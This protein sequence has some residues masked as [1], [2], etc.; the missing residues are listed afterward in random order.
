MRKSCGE[1]IRQRIAMDRAEWMRMMEAYCD[2][3]KEYVM[4]KIGISDKQ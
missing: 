2:V 4:A 1:A 3:P